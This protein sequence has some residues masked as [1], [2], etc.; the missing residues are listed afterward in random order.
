MQWLFMLSAGIAPMPRLQF[1]DIIFYVVMT[2]LIIS[3]IFLCFL[4]TK[5]SKFK[6]K[7]RR[8]MEE[9]K[10]EYISPKVIKVNNNKE[11]LNTDINA[12]KAETKNNKK[13]SIIK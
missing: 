10:R 8:V 11:D 3:V 9:N 1:Q 4:Y 12:N 7:I 13:K 5:S 2:A 6:I